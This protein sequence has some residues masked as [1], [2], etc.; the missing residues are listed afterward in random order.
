[1]H[2]LSQ[3]T[4]VIQNSVNEFFQSSKDSVNEVRELNQASHQNFGVTKQVERTFN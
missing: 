4:E 2:N 3:H 1:M